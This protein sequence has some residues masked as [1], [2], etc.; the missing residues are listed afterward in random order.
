[1]GGISVFVWADYIGRVDQCIP[2]P[3]RVDLKIC[4]AEEWVTYRDITN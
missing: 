1:M 3:V 2:P 4:E